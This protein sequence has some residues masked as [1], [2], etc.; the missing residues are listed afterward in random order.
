VAIYE[1]FL[2]DDEIQ[3]MV[4][5]HAGTSELRKA[6]IERGMKVLR[7]DG[8]AKVAQGATSINEIQRITS[9]FEISYDLGEEYT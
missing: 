3:D 4:A 8:W 9:N 1:F 5:D 6:A 7:Q 2:L